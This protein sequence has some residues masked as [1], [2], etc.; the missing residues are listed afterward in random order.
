ME[1]NSQI[2]PKKQKDLIY[3]FFAVRPANI[4]IKGERVFYTTAFDAIEAQTKGDL[5]VKERLGLPSSIKALPYGK[6]SV[7]ELLERAEIELPQKQ[8]KEPVKQ[9]K[10][11]KKQFFSSMM[12]IKDT[13]VK[14]SRDKTTL[15]RIIKKYGNL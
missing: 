6:I 15:E 10:Y 11:T 5:Y 2:T 9:E 14:E 12:L 4:A 1:L 13:F 3:Y 7:A 8:K